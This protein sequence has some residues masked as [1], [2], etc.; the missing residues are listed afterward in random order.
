MLDP[1]DTAYG[2][3]IHSDFDPAESAKRQ[4]TGIYIALVCAWVLDIS[5]QIILWFSF[6]DK[7]LMNLAYNAIVLPFAVP[8]TYAALKEFEARS[9]M[10]QLYER[11]IVERN[12]ATGE[13]DKRYDIADIVV[14]L[15]DPRKDH[16]G[17]VLQAG[18]RRFFERLPRRF[19]YNEPRFIAS[20]KALNV[21][22]QQDVDK[23]G[24][25]GLV[26][27]FNDRARGN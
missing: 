6:D 4:R 1:G 17:L 27:D 13:E 2:R 15:V 8:V 26:D 23:D 20:L 16:I 22:L 7:R 14:L 21:P 19:I 9:M 18:G 24:L 5:I 12:L 3:L 10:V 25:Q 11:A